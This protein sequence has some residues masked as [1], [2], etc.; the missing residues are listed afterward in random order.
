MKTDKNFRL[1]QPAKRM[2]ALIDD[3][4]EYSFYK[5]VFIENQVEKNRVRKIVTKEKASE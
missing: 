1:N 2:L 4:S 3:K 5:N